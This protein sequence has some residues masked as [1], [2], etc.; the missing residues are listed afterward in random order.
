VRSQE[1]L[2]SITVHEEIESPTEF[3]WMP[4]KC[5]NV[6][7]MVA[8][9][10]LMILYIVGHRSPPCTR[11]RARPHTHTHRDGP[12]DP[13]KPDGLFVSGQAELAF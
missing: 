10:S 8:E 5:P 9:F 13:S 6:A 7:L 1:G 4:D 2:Y 3:E 12:T 11:T